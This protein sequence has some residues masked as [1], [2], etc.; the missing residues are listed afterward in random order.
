MI[1]G[2]VGVLIVLLGSFF[3]VLDI[4]F[5]Q[6]SLGCAV[7]AAVVT[8]VLTTAILL[9]LMRAF[10]AR[11]EY[12]PTVPLES[13]ASLQFSLKQLFLLTTLAS[14]V[15]MGA[16]GVRALYRMEGRFG[17]LAIAVFSL[18]VGVGHP[19]IAL[20]SATACFASRQV[21]IRMGLVAVTTCTVALF[22]LLIVPFDQVGAIFYSGSTVIG[23]L[24]VLA[25]LLVFRRYGYRLVS[26][27][28]LP[29]TASS[30]Q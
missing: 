4:I 28:I 26:V 8:P 10:H 23:T 1:C 21:L 7:S 9:G 16:T 6:R 30:P 27:K 14:I 13:I 11:L 25:T 22:P 19:L 3:D 24:F 20:A 15:L 5:Y 12:R 17:P 2:A 29:E 18:V